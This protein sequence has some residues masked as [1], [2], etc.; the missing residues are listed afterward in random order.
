MRRW[1]IGDD[2]GWAGRLGTVIAA[3][4]LSRFSGACQLQY[5][6]VVS[7][8]SLPSLHWGKETW[9]TKGSILGPGDAQLSQP[10]ELQGDG[11]HRKRN[12]SFSKVEQLSLGALVF[13]NNN[14]KI[15]LISSPCVVQF[16]FFWL[17]IDIFSVFLLSHDSSTLLLFYC[18]Y[19]SSVLYFIV[20]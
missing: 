12:S 7:F 5:P 11:S 4:G 2:D 16:S 1:N 15:I 8:H 18:F 17:Y 3:S 10:C 9:W 13:N 14:N 20:F 6:Q 19:L